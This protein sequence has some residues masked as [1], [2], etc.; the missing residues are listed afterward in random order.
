MNLGNK[1]ILREFVIISKKEWLEKKEEFKKIKQELQMENKDIFESCFKQSNDDITSIKKGT[2]IILKDLPEKI[3][4][5]EIKIW[6]S[7]FIEPAYVDYNSHKRECVIRFSHGIFADSFL[8]KFN[9]D[10]NE[11]ERKL[12]DKIIQ[13]EKMEGDEEEK[14]ILKVENLMKDFSIKKQ[15]KKFRTNSLVTPQD[16]E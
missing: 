10:E 3:N 14:Y 2:L 5:N 8:N 4:K 6:V 13:I 12:N 9:N 1:K 16:Q 11:N 15:N 7:N